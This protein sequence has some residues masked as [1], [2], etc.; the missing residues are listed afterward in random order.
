MIVYMLVVFLLAYNG[1]TS[2]FLGESENWTVKFIIN[3][4]NK[5]VEGNY[6]AE[7]KGK[8]LEELLKKEVHYQV[9][10]KTSSSGGSAYLNDK[11]ILEG[12]AFK[13]GCGWGCSYAEIDSSELIFTVMI[14]GESENITLNPSR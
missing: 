8:N 1:K 7:F 12:T 14:D 11:G 9:D 13:K 4:N 6:A 5:L 10:Y 2:T 3:K